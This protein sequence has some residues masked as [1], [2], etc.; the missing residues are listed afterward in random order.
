MTKLSEV[1]RRFAAARASAGANDPGTGLTP[2]QQIL[3]DIPGQPDAPDPEPVNLRALPPALPEPGSET[4][5]DQLRYTLKCA[6]FEL[7][8]DQE[9]LAALAHARERAREE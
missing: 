7:T 8:H 3:T 4:E 6:I 5:L 9:R 1:G 2:A